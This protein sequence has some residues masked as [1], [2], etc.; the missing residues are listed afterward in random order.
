[1]HYT[2]GAKTSTVPTGRGGEL[3][4]WL[5]LR[6][7]GNRSAEITFTEEGAEGLAQTMA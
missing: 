1:M 2:T 6:T 4:F 5:F 7:G 3:I